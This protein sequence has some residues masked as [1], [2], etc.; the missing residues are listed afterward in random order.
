MAL[1]I[2]AEDLK[3]VLEIEASVGSWE[4]DAVKVGSTSSAGLDVEW[5]DAKLLTFVNG[6]R[7]DSD[8]GT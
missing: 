4:F 5:C 8:S 3:K 1:L 6:P 7:M 2:I